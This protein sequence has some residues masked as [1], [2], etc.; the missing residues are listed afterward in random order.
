MIKFFQSQISLGLVILLLIACTQKENRIKNARNFIKEWNYERALTEIISYR[1]KKDPEIQYLLGLCYLKKNEFSEAAKYFEKSLT[2]SENYT[3]S[4]LQLYN[5]MAHNALKINE[6]QR[7]LFFYR[8]AA[9]LVPEFNQA[10]N[11]FLT[12]DINFE[13]DNYAVA[14][15]AYLKALEYDSTSPRAKKIR[16][17]LIKALMETDSLN[18]ALKLATTE[19]ERL[20]TASNL[21]QLSEIKFSIGKELFNIGLIDSAWIFFDEIVHQQEPKSLMDDAYFYIG[22]IYLQKGQWANALKSYKKVIR[23]NPYEKGEIIKRAKERIKEIK[24]QR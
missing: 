4:I 23:L 7:A 19:Y 16:K 20:P 1:D 11:L 5:T 3:D 15:E 8:E 21:L 22:E 14:A 18:L 17:N 9:S 6:P 13:Q 24:E 2:Y 10:D 12:G